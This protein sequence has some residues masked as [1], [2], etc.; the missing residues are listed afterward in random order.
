MPSKAISLVY[1]NEHD[2]LHAAS[3]AYC[4]AL[5]AAGYTTEIVD[6]AASDGTERL[7]KEL[8]NPELA[9]CFGLQGVGSCLTTKAGQNLWSA[10]HLP[11]ICLHWDHPCHNPFNHFNES[12][13]VGNL[14][15]FQS[16]LES[17]QRY[18]P[19]RQISD[20]A[21][22]ECTEIPPNPVLAFRDRPIKLLFMKTGQ[23]VQDLD[24]YINSLPLLV[25]NGVW[26]QL[27]RAES[28]PN[29]LLCDLV[30]EI[31]ESA[32]FDRTTHEPQFW[33]IVQTMDIYLRRKRAIN[34]VDWLKLQEGAMIIGDGWDFIDKLGA[35]ATF[36]PALSVNQSF[37]LYGQAQF[38]C[39]TSPYGRDII[40]ERAVYG[41]MMG[42]CVLTDVNNWW[43]E[44]MSDVPALTLY[45]PGLP[46][47]EQLAS[48]ITNS[49]AAEN[50]SIAR[51]LAVG[52][53][54]SGSTEITKLLELVEQVKCFANS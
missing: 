38:I 43:R 49:K 41:L 27:Q 15:H 33:G 5:H 52:R 35:K 31:F 32:G 19:S 14:Y 29:H 2:A 34:F 26:S 42:G 40:H 8:A 13:F 11:F 23:S 30:A 7:A 16:F 9:F 54:A 6:L 4:R 48:A 18:L 10:K 12:P 39:N 21:P 36:K 37:Q 45:D 51:S 47:D 24:E 28:Q 22:F 50:A 44:N 17:K 1:K 25:R 53:F 20:F 46:L 3:L